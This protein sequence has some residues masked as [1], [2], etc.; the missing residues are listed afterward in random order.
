L[1]GKDFIYASRLAAV[2][3]L[4]YTTIFSLMFNV[5]NKLNIEAKLVP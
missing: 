4:S 1:S 2:R 3:L 5:I